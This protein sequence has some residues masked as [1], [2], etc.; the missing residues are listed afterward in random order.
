MSVLP[1]W[2][3]AQATPIF[4]GDPYADWGTGG[5]GL[6]DD[7]E[8]PGYY[9]WANDVARTSWSV[10]W[11][12]R[13]WETSLYS[14]YDWGGSIVFS[15]NEG[16][17]DAVQVLW[18]ANDGGLTIWDSGG[19]DTIM[20]GI[21]HAGPGWDGFDFTIRG[22]VGDYLT[23]NLFSSFFTPEN[24]GVYVGGNKLSVLDYCDSSEAFRSGDGENRQF[25]I[26]APVPEPATLMLLGSGL[27]VLGG[28]VRRRK[29]R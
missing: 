16:I 26:A 15:N 13:D 10:R 20:Y 27:V 3:T 21:A 9:I 22:V 28:W 4:T 12:G 8:G 24:D 11:T 7:P 1:F 5:T 2:G 19:S 17:E 18:E 29:A 23:F 6:P 14:T 25:E